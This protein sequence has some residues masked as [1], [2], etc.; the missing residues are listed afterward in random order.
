MVTVEDLSGDDQSRLDR[1][2]QLESGKVLYFAQAPFD[3]PKDEIEFLLRQRQTE[4]SYH[5][6][7]AYRPL[8]DRVSGT[9]GMSPP[10]LERLQDCMRSFSGRV[11][12][13]LSDF[14]APYA[15]RWRL[16]Y[17]SFRPFQEKGRTVRLRARNDLLHLDNF[18]T[19]PTNGDLILRFFTNINPEEPRRW[20]T[21]EPFERVVESFAGSGQL[22][23]PKPLSGWGRFKYAARK[24]GRR[25]G[26][27]LIARPPYDEFMLRLHHVMKED[28]GFQQNC[29]K[30]HLE[31]PPGS[32][33]MVF[34][35][36]VPHAAL[37]GQY[38]L[39]QTFMISKESLIDP[40]KA[41]LRIL[42][43]LCGCQPL[44]DPR[45]A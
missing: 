38:A 28:Q 17:A 26:L 42:E 32:C 34:T 39:E 19:R 44:D 40:A 13:F 3:F 24:A 22:P 2:R 7:I 43:E 29:S 1:C 12:G 25:L 27:P 5:K 11:V 30:T 16:D 9:Q 35:D 18:P 21:S 14:L 6:N 10:D 15:S 36:R 41:P 45:A 4:A 37:S 31:F 33:W 20:I 23:W 8:S